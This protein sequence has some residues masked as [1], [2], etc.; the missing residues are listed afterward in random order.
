MTMEGVTMRAKEIAYL[1]KTSEGA[2]EASLLLHLHVMRS[3]YSYRAP[4]NDSR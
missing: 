2:T 3:F 1:K 4:S